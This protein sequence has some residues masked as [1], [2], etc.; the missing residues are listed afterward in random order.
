MDHHILVPD[1]D[2]ELPG[3]T[4][5]QPLKSFLLSQ[6]SEAMNFLM[7]IST[8]TFF[9]IVLVIF[10]YCYAGETVSAQCSDVALVIAQTHWYRY[11]PA[12]QMF[13]ILMIA[14]SQ[15]PF[16]FTGFKVT[17]CSLQTFT[18]VSFVGGKLFVSFQ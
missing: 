14:R 5:R 15:K 16:N 1:I 3:I 2:G 8:S 6:T 18:S 17:K 11:P 13:M 10:I 9:V 12:L 4:N 7:V